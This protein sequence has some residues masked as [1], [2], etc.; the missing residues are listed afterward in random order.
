MQKAQP[1]VMDYQNALK[2]LQDYYSFRKSNQVDF[3]YEAWSKE[4]KYK[5]RSYLRFVVLGKRPLNEALLELFLK[6]F[7][8]S[9]NEAE[10]FTILVHYTQSKSR[11]QRNIFGRRLI[12]LAHRHS[13]I[14]EAQQHYD[15]LS[16][17]LMPKLQTLIGFED[18][19][20]KAEEIAQLLDISAEEIKQALQFLKES[21]LIEQTSLGH[22][23]SLKKSWA[24][25]ASFQSMALVEFYKNALHE[26]EQAIQLPPSERRFRSLFLAMSEVEFQEY[27]QE[28]EA[29]V[30]EQLHKRNVSHLKDRRLY[31]LNFNFIPAS[32]K[33]E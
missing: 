18:I 13:P 5:N 8:F 33:F 1:H 28:F 6:F 20:A 31:Q 16:N 19:P 26:A 30:K 25:P 22:W 32:K 17:P 12:A 4:I 10:Y 3:S 15:F 21:K 9:E 27:L 2:F 11:E 24:T 29:F 14:I 7:S 23:R